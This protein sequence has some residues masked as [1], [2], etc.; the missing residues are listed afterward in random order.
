M[1]TSV[2]TENDI[3]KGLVRR[4]AVSD[5]CKELNTQ[6][7]SSPR[8]DDGHGT[9]QQKGALDVQ[10]EQL[11]TIARIWTALSKLI[12]SQCNKNRI[13]DSLYFG[14][15]GKTSVCVGDSSAPNTYSYCPGPRSVFKLIEN[16]E[17]I[18]QVSQSVSYHPISILKRVFPLLPDFSRSES[19]P[20]SQLIIAI[21]EKL[22]LSG[23]ALE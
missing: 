22:I 14:S 5:L 20:L 7:P 12:R 4:G 11:R 16:A 6:I 2:L 19:T 3:L 18:K 21:Y 23:K 15:F 1:T 13:I 17:N 10:R 9:P 8:A